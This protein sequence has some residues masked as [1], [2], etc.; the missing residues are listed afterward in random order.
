[1]KKLRLFLKE[2][3]EDDEG[4]TL[5]EMLASITII[6]FIIAIASPNIFGLIEK[7][8][9][10]SD[11]ATAKIIAKSA[12]LYISEN[13]NDLRSNPNKI[14]DHGYCENIEVLIKKNYLLEV[15]KPQDKKF[16]YFS[17]QVDEDKIE[18]LKSNDEK[19]ESLFKIE[20]E[21]NDYE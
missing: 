4:F 11:L 1:M 17:L 5:M 2:F 12:E 13:E 19:E 6:T 18:V 15:V 9:D 3:N 21:S 20:K 16:N 10:K 8:K 7:S 14:K